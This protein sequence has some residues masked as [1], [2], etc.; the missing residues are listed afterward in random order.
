MMVISDKYE[1]RRPRD[2]AG[3]AE[4][5]GRTRVGDERAVQNKAAA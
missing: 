3:M 4:G 1:K 5:E 2:Q